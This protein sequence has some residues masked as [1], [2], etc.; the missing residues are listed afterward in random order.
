MY[1]KTQQRISEPFHV[2]NWI[3][4]MYRVLSDRLFPPNEQRLTIL[5]WELFP[6][7]NV[8]F[9][10]AEYNYYLDYFPT[11]HV[12]STATTWPLFQDRRTFQQVRAEYL[13]R[14]PQNKGRVSHF[15]RWRVLPPGLGYTNFSIAAFQFVEQFEKANLPFIFTL[16]PGFGFQLGQ[17]ASDAMIRRVLKSPC[18]R[19]VIVTQKISHEY[20]LSK[21]WCAPSQIEFIYGCVIPNGSQSGQT[22]GRR[23]YQEDKRTFDICFVAHKHMP[24]G[25]DKGYDIFIEAAKALAKVHPD[26][27]FHVVG[28]FNEQDI[29]V[30]ELSDRLRFYWSQA[31][32]FF[33]GFYK[34]MDVILSPNIPFTWAPGAF[35]GFPTAA[36]MEAGIAGV[37]VFCTDPLHQNFIFREGEE[38]VIIPHDAQSICD[39]VEHYRHDYDALH[40]LSLKGQEAFRRVFDLEAQMAPRLHLMSAYLKPGVPGTIN[41]SKPSSLSC[42]EKRNR[43]KV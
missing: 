8:G 32:D 35:D 37:A 5:D 42:N 34:E 13:K 22:I 20:L 27:R 7:P 29:D 12:A 39:Q 33:T 17:K 4:D 40:R 28:E 24:R 1:R 11:A 15:N 18:F 6:Y 41:R 3:E 19:K 36:C 26:F 43:I 30:R 9:L 2:E 14:Y 16:Y 31:T 25:V 23:H 10:I 38:I 21:S